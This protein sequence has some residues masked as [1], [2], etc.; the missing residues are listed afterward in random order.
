[1]DRQRSLCSPSLCVAH[2]FRRSDVW[3][4]QECRRIRAG[5]P[6]VKLL[7][8][9]PELASRAGPAS[10]P[11][12]FSGQEQ[13]RAGLNALTPEE[14]DK[15]QQL[16]TA[17]REKFGFPFI[18]AVRRASTQTILSAFGSRLRNTR[19]QELA[20]ALTQ[21]EKIAWMRLLE[22]VPPEPTGFLTCHVLD[23]A[24]GIP[25]AG[26]Q[27]RLRRL[28]GASFDGLEGGAATKAFVTNADGRLEGPA[29]KGPEFRAG[30]YEW[31]FEVG[32]YFVRAGV[33]TVGQPF[34]DVVPLRFGIDNP[35]EHYHVPLLCSPWSY[36][37]YRGS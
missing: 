10:E 1:M 26:V 19:A 22:V 14:L 6:K 17:Y 18:L 16:N 23:T 28:D 5:P 34:L 27:V 35:E 20:Q 29:L 37:T 2:Q 12:S 3:R 30:A 31:E 33:P 11:S 9:Y 15:F 25:A 32:D 7:S 24:R 13:A 21:V 8:S 4:R 36:S